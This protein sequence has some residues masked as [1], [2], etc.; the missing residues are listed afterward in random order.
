MLGARRWMMPQRAFPLLDQ[1]F[2]IERIVHSF[3]VAIDGERELVC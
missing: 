1:A 2:L 3:I